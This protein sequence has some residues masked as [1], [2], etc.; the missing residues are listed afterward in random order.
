MKNKV[1]FE[2]YESRDGWRWHA[3]R[4]GRIIAESA[5]AYSRKSKAAKTLKN[6]LGAVEQG[7]FV[8]V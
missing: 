4:S 1:K 7:A 8:I 3:K 6:L 5:E 2:L